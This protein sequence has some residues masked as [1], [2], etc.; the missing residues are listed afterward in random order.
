[1][2][3]NFP[4]GLMVKQY[5]GVATSPITGQKYQILATGKRGSYLCYRMD[6]DGLFVT[7]DGAV[8]TIKTAKDW[9]KNWLR[10][11]PL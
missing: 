11:C 3:L 7:G 10:G 4:M 9:F 6:S 5:I 2:A 1:M 8:V